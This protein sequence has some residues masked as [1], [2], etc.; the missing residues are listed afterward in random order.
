MI[1]LIMNKRGP[2]ITAPA[3]ARTNSSARPFGNLPHFWPPM[4]WP[5]SRTPN[6][7]AS[8]FSP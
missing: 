3:L 4:V 7:F 8:F 6:G 2:Q 5:S 1:F